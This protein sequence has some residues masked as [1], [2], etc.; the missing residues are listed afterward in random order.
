MLA[1]QDGFQVEVGEGAQVKGHQVP[2]VWWAF[3]GDSA[4]SAICT[5]V[6]T[7]RLRP[8]YSPVQVD[9]KDKSVTVM[10]KTLLTSIVAVVIVLPMPRRRK[11]P[12]SGTGTQTSP[13]DVPANNRY[14]WR[15]LPIAPS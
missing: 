2:F 8:D 4:L 12:G 5:L 11:S 6:L 1:M 13:S 9:K 7:R 3:E 14:Y 15:P 10:S